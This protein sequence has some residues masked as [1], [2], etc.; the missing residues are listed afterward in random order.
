MK[1][2]PNAVAGDAESSDPPSLY[3]RGSDI[4]GQPGRE[5]KQPDICLTSTPGRATGNTMSPVMGANT[6]SVP[7]FPTLDAL[8]VTGGCLKTQPKNKG[9][10]ATGGPGRGKRGSIV[11]PRL[12][13]TL[14][15]QHITKRE[16]VQ[17]QQVY[18]VGMSIRRN[19]F[20][21]I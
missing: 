19:L 10:A 14:A 16:S 15:E 11:L 20:E 2:F 1:N 12:S 7:E 3:R 5:L 8:R 4:S 9:T 13:L 17:A 18:E 21:T 6:M